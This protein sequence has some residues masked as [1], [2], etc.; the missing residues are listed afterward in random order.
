MIAIVD[1]GMGNVRSVR[2]A[3]LA[4]GVET[5]L[6]F[7]P[8][9]LEC[10][11]GI[12]LPG[13][14]AF[15]DGMKHLRERGLPK[16]LEKIVLQDGKPFLG[17]CLGLQLVARR[18]FELGEHEGLGW[19]DADVVPLR[20]PSREFR[21]PHMGWN[22]AIVRRPGRLLSELGAEP[23]FYFVHS[24]HLKP[25]NPEA[26][27]VAA[28]SCHG[29]RFVA[30]FEKGNLFGVQF[31]PEKSQEAGLKLLSNFL[32]VCGLNIVEKAAAL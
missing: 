29:E 13:V 25:A 19:L 2:N 4:L 27:W 21:V 23:V 8:A 16:V 31:H 18:S 24:F 12:I 26:D 6:T 7:D 30:A 15:G 20:P 17:I 3:F 9:R 1:Y 11:A 5:E 32:A 10:A 22:E 14:G 28:E